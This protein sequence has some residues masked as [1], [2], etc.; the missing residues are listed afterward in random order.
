M[1]LIN[2]SN[3]SIFTH[4]ND[5]IS[6]DVKVK[7]RNI[8]NFVSI[9]YIKSL[10]TSVYLCE[11]TF[12]GLICRQNRPG[13][14]DSENG[15]ISVCALQLQFQSFKPINTLLDLHG[16]IVS[17]HHGNPLVVNKSCKCDLRRL[18]ELCILIGG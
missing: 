8:T 18:G 3:W 17:D 14:S 5:D 12:R 10:V 13:Q 15:I 11:V 1:F 2:S 4:F 6:L 16:R 7:K 9:I